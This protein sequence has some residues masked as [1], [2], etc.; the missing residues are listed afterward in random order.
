MIFNEDAVKST[1]LWRRRENCEK[2]WKNSIILFYMDWEA[3]Y[4]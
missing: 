4:E 2:K 1:I 3:K